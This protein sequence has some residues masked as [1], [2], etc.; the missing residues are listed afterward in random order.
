MKGRLTLTDIGDVLQHRGV[1]GYADQQLELVIRSSEPEANNQGRQD[2][3]GHRIDPPSY[4]GTEDSAGQ[5]RP[6]DEEI[7]PVIFPK[8]ADLAVCVA[9]SVAVQEEAE[10][11]CESNRDDDC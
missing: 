10:L 6:V 4:F 11:G 8:D 5:T 9:E 2:Q 1:C 3:G 7:V